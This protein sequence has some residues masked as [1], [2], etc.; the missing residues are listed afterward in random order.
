MS[1]MYEPPPGLKKAEEVNETPGERYKFDWQRTW[2]N[3]PRESWVSKDELTNDRPFGISVRHV[4][5]VKC[6][7]FGHINTDKECPLY[8]KVNITHDR[9]LLMV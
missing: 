7:K 1:F 5:C 8:G 3:A 4:R 2:G 9:V 6:R